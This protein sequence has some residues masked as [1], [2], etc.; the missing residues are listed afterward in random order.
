[1]NDRINVTTILKSA[2]NSAPVLRQLTLVKPATV[3]IPKKILRLE[4][5]VNKQSYI[6]YLINAVD[7]SGEG[8]NYYLDSVEETEARNARS[9]EDS[10]DD[11]INVN[12]DNLFEVTEFRCLYNIFCL[13]Y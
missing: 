2:E 11:F 1:M 7:P 13:F 9:T 4:N 3:T 10:Y 5:D 8:L 12:R 6:V